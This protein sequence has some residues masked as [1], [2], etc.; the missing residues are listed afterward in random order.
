MRRLIYSLLTL[1][2][3]ALTAGHVDAQ[4]VTDAKMTRDQF[5]STYGVS[6]LVNG[7]ELSANP[8]PYKDKI[9]AV[10][11]NF[12]RMLSESEAMFHCCAKSMGYYDLI[13]TGLSSTQFTAAS[14]DSVLAIKVTGLTRLK[15]SQ[16]G[17]ESLPAGTFVGVYFCS[18]RRCQD[19]FGER[20]R[21]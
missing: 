15:T 9:V 20:S 4:S 13:V 16:G 12:S 18:L 11:A 1:C 5:M 8:F 19:F 21:Y 7:F 17:E 14:K 10:R 2:L 3:G 6:E